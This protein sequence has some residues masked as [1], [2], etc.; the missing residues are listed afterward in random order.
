M[1]LTALISV[2]AAVL[3][4]GL[5]ETSR[6][7][8]DRA[9]GRQQGAHLTAEFD[10]SKATEAQL[11]ATADTA[12]VAAAAGPYRVASVRVRMPQMPAGDEGPALTVAGRADRAPDV[13]RVDLAKG[14]WAKAAGEIVLDQDAAAVVPIGTKVRAGDVE[15]E[16]VGIAKSA[17]RSADAWMVP[18]QLAELDQ[19]RAP[20]YQML[21]RLDDAGSRADISRGRAA[22]AGAL[23]AKAVTGTQSYLTVKQDVDSE[24]AVYVPFLTAFAV[25][26]L[27]LSVLVVAVVVSGAVTAATRRIGVLKAL[28]F[29]PVQVGRAYVAQAVLPAVVGVV[30]GAVTANLL[31]ALLTDEVA[32]TYG[33]GTALIPLWVDLAVPA[34]VLAL[35]AVTALVPALRAGRLRSTQALTVGRAPSPGRALL[36]RRLLGR[37]PVSRPVGLGLAHPFAR[38][39]RTATLAAAV[40][41]G[42]LAVTFAV[43]LNSS[44]AAIQADRQRTSA[45]DVL[46]QSGPGGG[47]GEHVPA[48]GAEPQKP[49]DPAKVAAAVRKAPGTKSYFGIARTE[50]RVP[51]ATGRT[52]AI[53]YAGDARS[54]AY[55][56]IDGRWFR[57]EGEVV[58][59]SRLLQAM[60]AEVG[61]TVTL[62][63]KGRT[64]ELRIVGEAFVLDDDG[65]AV[66]MDQADQR[67]LTPGTRSSEYHVTLRSGSDA[68]AYVAAINDRFGSQG[69]HAVKGDSAGIRSSSI[70]AMQAMISLL[71][72]ML[73]AVACLGVLNTVVLDTRERLHDLGVFKAL[74]MSPRQTVSM[75]LVS[76]AAVGL[77]AGAP[78]TLLGV[79][80]HHWVTPEMGATAGTRLPDATID[81]YDASLLA[82]LAAGGLVIATL[83]ALLPAS[84]AAKS[85]T[86]KALRTE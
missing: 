79:A 45:G 61:D 6:A 18:A 70:I 12:G 57:G 7:P 69:V 9:F 49:A 85:G 42:A 4:I 62:T 25:I 29:T 43:G 21:Y 30:L 14:R 65:M 76:V 64:V 1:A 3:A 72:A 73:V 54:G 26:G 60:D 81:V 80:L 20:A 86:A 34:A 47:P 15:L 59:A 16:V 35:I 51:G 22:V 83:G 63:D 13:D 19:G 33:V 78:G 50:V 31:G 53:G 84:W 74:G 28:G 11:R 2:A 75:V 41:F 58:V 17:G 82:L 32:A 71:A 23:P 44:L 52:T 8:F 48:P 36:V 10:G 40:A 55:R 77:V 24:A 27:G 67:R 37:L 56:M 68:D 66:V 39:A 5:I 38:P 46:V